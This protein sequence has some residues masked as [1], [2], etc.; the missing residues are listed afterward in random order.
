MPVD[1]PSD[2]SS[3]LQLLEWRPLHHKTLRGFVTLPLRP[4]LIIHDLPVHRSGESLF[5]LMP[6]KPLFDKDGRV[7][8][9]STA[10]PSTLVVR[11]DPKA[12]Q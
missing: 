7:L 9:T 10:R 8:T 11:R 4:G 12:L 6:G 3:R 5:A 1:P 2:A